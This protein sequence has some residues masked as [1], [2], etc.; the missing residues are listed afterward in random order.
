MKVLILNNMDKIKTFLMTLFL[1]FVSCFL[2]SCTDLSGI[3]SDVENLTNRV[4]S[5]ENALAL[6]KKAQEE[7][8]MIRSVESNSDG[9]GWVITFSDNQ[10]LTLLNGEYNGKLIKNIDEDKKNGVISLKLID[11]SEFLFN[12]DV[13]YPTGISALTK[14]ILVSSKGTAVMDVIVNPSNAYI[15]IE[16]LQS[17]FSLNLANKTRASYLTTPSNYAIK[18]VE[19]V[20]GEDESGEDGKYRVTLEDLGK[21]KNYL[22]DITLVLS[23][24]DGKGSDI[25]ISSDLVNIKW[26]NGDDFHDFMIGGVSGIWGDNSITINLPKGTDVSQLCPTFCTNGTVYVGGKVQVSGVSKQNFT[27]AKEYVVYDAVWKERKYKV[28]VSLQ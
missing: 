4:S 15:D 13:S 6:L 18:Q 23:T 5:L 11:G 20:K 1:V 27:T 19:K 21:K 9:T 25:L 12:L 14:N 17:S 22:E 24:K 10:I 26:Y 3:E 2:H 28:S 7:S 16:S 8:K